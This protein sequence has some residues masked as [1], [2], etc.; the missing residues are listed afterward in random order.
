MKITDCDLH[1]LNLKTNPTV[2]LFQNTPRDVIPT[3]TCLLSSVFIK[4]GPPE[5]PFIVSLP[6]IKSPKNI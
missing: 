3:T 5:S 6:S 1:I 2:I 4:I